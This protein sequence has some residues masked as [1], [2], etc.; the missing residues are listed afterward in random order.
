MDRLQE[1]Y[2]LFTKL[3]ALVGPL[4]RLVDHP[5]QFDEQESARVIARYCDE[6]RR[7]ASEMKTFSKGEQGHDYLIQHSRFC[8]ALDEIKVGLEYHKKLA[9]LLPI[10]T[11]KAQAAI[12]SIPV[13]SASVILEA[14]SP[15]TAY[16]RLRELCEVDTTASL[17]WLDPYLDAS[18]FHRYLQDVRP[19]ATIALVT[20]AP[21]PTA[22]RREQQ[23]WSE[24]LDISRL[25][26]RERPSSYR[27]LL[28][29]SLHDRWLVLDSRRIYSLGGSAKDA[30]AKDHFT[31]S[32]VD[33][34]PA[35]LAIIAQ[36]ESSGVELF[37]P[38]TPQH[39]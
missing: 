6:H 17:A 18:V 38:S 34:T 15:F 33:G 10:A 31:I 22:S 8:N 9:D 27:L 25:F 2:I 13:P 32:A 23:R 7:L 24:F 12:D 19:T 21:Q 1:K 3:G 37:G 20:C 29:P 16:C 36:H 26:A 4:Q 5:E 35:N 30:A 14:G 28:E 39:A 11:V